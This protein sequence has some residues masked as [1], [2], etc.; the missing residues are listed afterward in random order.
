MSDTSTAGSGLR[1]LLDEAVSS[2][3]AATRIKLLDTG[4]LNHGKDFVTFLAAE[5]SRDSEKWGLLHTEMH[6]RCRHWLKGE[7][8]SERADEDARRA[9]FA[10]WFCAQV[11]G[12]ARL[13][14]HIIAKLPEGHPDRD[15]DAVR[16]LLMRQMRLA[17]EQR[18]SVG[19]ALDSI[20]GLL[21]LDLLP[22]DRLV[23]LID[24][25]W[26]IV[27]RQGWLDRNDNF[28]VSAIA[29]LHQFALRAD[30][31]L[32]T[33]SADWF[34]AEAARI[35]TSLG[36]IADPY[37]DVTLL[38]SMLATGDVV[39]AIDLRRALLQQEQPD[40][41][42]TD[43]GRMAILAE[44]GDRYQLKQYQSVID[45]LTPLLPGLEERYLTAIEPKDV[46]EA[47]R[48]LAE[49]LRSVA[50][51]HAALGE[52][53]AALR[54][55]DR[56]KSLRLRYERILRE[57][58]EAERVLKLQA[59]LLALH[60][61]LDPESAPAE[62]DAAADPVGAQLSIRSRLVEAYR[63]TRARL[64][65]GGLEGVE[66]AQIAATLGNDQAVLILGDSHE[67]LLVSIVASGDV[68][69]PWA[70]SLLSRAVR[71]SIVKFAA[72]PSNGWLVAMAAP[73]L[74]DEPALALNALLQ[75]FDY[76]VAKPVAEMLSEL[77]VKQLVVIPHNYLHLIPYWA[78]PSFAGLDVMM[79]PSAHHLATRR[80]E[81][82]SLRGRA[83]VVGNPTLDLPN[84]E[85][86]S[87]LVAEMLCDAGF[88][89]CLLR[90]DEA[91]EEAMNAAASGV[92]MLHFAGHGRSDLLR[93]LQ[94]SLEVHPGTPGRAVDG[95]DPLIT[96]AREANGGEWKDNERWADLP[97]HGRLYQR[98]FPVTHR[99]ELVLEYA[100][101]GTLLG[102][103]A[104]VLGASDELALVRLSELWSAGE[105]ITSRTLS[106]CG[107]A[108]LSSCEA[109]QGGLSTSLD[110]H[111]G[112]PAALELAGARALICPLWG[113]DDV[114]SAVFAQVFYE[115]LLA[116]CGEIDLNALVSQVRQALRGMTSAEAARRTRALAAR[117]ERA[118][119]RFK[120]EAEAYRIESTGTPPFA[121]PMS[122]AAFHVLGA[123]RFAVGDTPTPAASATGPVR[124]VEPRPS[125]ATRPIPSVEPEAAPRHGGESRQHLADLYVTLAQASTNAELVRQ[126]LGHLHER[127]RR[128]LK[129]RQFAEARVDLM[130]IFALEGESAEAHA[131][132][133]S[134]ALA[135]GDF[136]GAIEELD[137]AMTLNSRLAPAYRD[138]GLTWLARMD[139]KRALDDFNTALD[140][141]PNDYE[142]LV[143]RG[144]AW[145]AVGNLL[146]AV[147]DFDNAIVRKPGEATA[148]I[149]KA[150]AQAAMNQH[151]QAVETCGEA[152]AQR[153]EEGAAYLQRSGSLV[154]LQQIDRAFSD[155]ETAILLLPDP[156]P[157]HTQK[158]YFLA[159]VGE[160]ELAQL[161]YQR[162]IEANPEFIQA[163]FSRACALSMLE[164]AATI[165][166]DL[167]HAIDKFPSYRQL[168]ALAP[169]LK[170]ARDS[171]PGVRELLAESENA[172]SGNG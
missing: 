60:R 119:T 121:E 168:A 98:I 14:A 125:T 161:E 29:S 34:R 120:L 80:T 24:A 35:E 140:L 131:G 104:G 5:K 16:D 37:P 84:A 105:L 82:F 107:L 46:K 79:A 142:M 137:R 124:A 23:S 155:C 139:P 159:A 151:E 30:D 153:P 112:L 77:G 47:G 93:P 56:C 67:G 39:R 33:D 109:G 135:Q 7:R 136:N 138:R 115:E 3:H 100:A 110:E 6:A 130:R 40:G 49:A 160:L 83:L 171:V 122:W 144:M 127:V 88:E 28:R 25:G 97:P 19:S 169:E 118:G 157:A 150:T 43:I 12:L 61:G 36:Q 90:R 92:T 165:F 9:R 70:A 74:L 89:A 108:F 143:Q 59:D 42:P 58:P 101:H 22:E 126:A 78:L 1:R 63:E 87:A 103:Y 163:Y 41:P 158:G 111:A 38:R 170:W 167:R 96:L 64:P 113:V 53:S 86:E 72:D 57:S 45:L 141:M 48:E 76:F 123:T 11:P 132:L 2:S 8:L 94:S 172:G 55:L 27:Q 69:A 154:A 10:L 71:Q 81:S 52:W 20:G 156:S 146:N 91:T 99:T 73:G 95:R 128:R 102:Q 50:F 21:Q 68:E 149:G 166:E 106:A 147:V 51:S 26:R 65:V 4:L 162:A 152:I 133:G 134:L 116:H 18:I 44:A 54:V 62:V 32:D 15:L 75:A 117:A 31:G 17:V 129:R 148:Y 85:V 13:A 164:T 66:V 145:I 114:T